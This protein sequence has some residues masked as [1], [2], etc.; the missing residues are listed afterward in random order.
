ML[1][2]VLVGKPQNHTVLVAKTTLTTTKKKFIKTYRV[3]ATAMA[4]LYYKVAS[5]PL[6]STSSSAPIT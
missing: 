6:L 2:V 4:L 3:L 1:H 5:C